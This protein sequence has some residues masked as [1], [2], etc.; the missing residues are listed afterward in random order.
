MLHLQLSEKSHKVYY[1]KG[2]NANPRNSLHPFYQLILIPPAGVARCPAW[3]KGEGNHRCRVHQENRMEDF[4]RVRGPLVS[5]PCAGIQGGSPWSFRWMIWPRLARP[6]WARPYLPARPLGPCVWFPGLFLPGRGRPWGRRDVR[7]CCQ[8][9]FWRRGTE[10]GIGGSFLN[11]QSKE[12]ISAS[13][14]FG[15][16]RATVLFPRSHPPVSPELRRRVFP[17]R[18][19]R[20]LWVCP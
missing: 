14:V 11:F 6:L 2:L 8:P 18:S 17:L 12:M 19:T 3:G 16:K 20:G 15:S 1:N 9:G 7:T 13:F 10:C 5:V 4:P